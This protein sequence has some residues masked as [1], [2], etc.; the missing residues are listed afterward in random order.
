MRLDKWLWAARFF[1]TRGIA[2]TAIDG[3]K[4]KLNGSTA[5]RAKLVKPGDKVRVHVG[6]QNWEVNVLALNEQRRPAP[7]ARLLYAETPE[8]SIERAR[9]AEL[10]ILAPTPLV[11][12]KGRP[13]KRDRRQLSSFHE[14]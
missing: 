6:D 14:G 12:R 9:Q 2:G 3:G 4:V 10:K 1:K 7:E 11:E 5:K 13:T 8:S